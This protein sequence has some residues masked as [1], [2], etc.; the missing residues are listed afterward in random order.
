MDAVSA[1]LSRLDP[2]NHK[3]FEDYQRHLQLRNIGKNTIAT[4]LFKVY[5]FLIW[6]EFRNIREAR[7]EDLEGFYLHRKGTVRPA[8]AFGDL[9]E[10]RVFFKW[11]LPDKEIITFRPQRPRQDIPPEKVL[12]ADIVKE[13]LACC[14]SQRDRALVSIYW[15]S[16]ARLNEILDCNIGHV[17]FD[18]Y[19]AVISVNGKT[20]RRNIRLVSSMP[21]L[22]A[23]INMHP[24]KTDPN[25]PLFVTSRKRG[26]RE[27]S[28]LKE[29]TVDNLFKRLGSY[30][31][32]GKRTNPHSFRHGRLTQRG[33]QLTE[34]EL[35]EYAGWSRGSGMAAVYVHLSSRDIDNKILQVEGKLKDEEPILDPM[36]PV[37][38][39]RC[40]HENAPD[41]MFCDHCSMTLTDEGAA[42]VGV[43]RNLMSNPDDLI[44]YAEWRKKQPIKIV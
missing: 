38:C 16:A 39:P 28:R 33:K 35:R 30:T 6:S 14:E 18:R 32:C 1:M 10:L 40:K 8:T 26:T 31:E 41:A 3:I 13:I 23:W 25:A 11:L 2:V 9:Q 17:Q 42:A 27:F 15:D 20:G 36:A 29:R 19:G 37:L 7:P 4:K 22:Q 43:V 21:D 34:S 24:L 44:A 12:T 5:A